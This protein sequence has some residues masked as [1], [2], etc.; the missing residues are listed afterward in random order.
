MLLWP[1]LVLN[2]D[3]LSKLKIELDI[4]GEVC[5]LLTRFLL[6][7]IGD[8]LFEFCFETGTLFIKDNGD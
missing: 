2:V 5:C 8:C 7:A 3:L 4:K 1:L 6:S